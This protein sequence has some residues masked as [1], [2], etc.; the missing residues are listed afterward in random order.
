MF[1]T[2]EGPEGGGK[3]SAMSRLA[4]WLS[5]QTVSVVTTREP[6][7]TRLGEKIRSLLLDGDEP[8]PLASL[9]LFETARVQLVSTVIQPALQQGSMVLCDR[10]SDSTLAYQGYGDGLS[11]DDIRVLNRVATGGL[12][13][14]LTVL[15]DID[16]A[17]GLRRRD[18]AG[19]LN[20]MDRRDLDFHRRVREGFLALAAQEP[21]RWL[22]LDAAESPDV[23]H[24]RIV[25][26]ISSMIVLR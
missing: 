25:E 6:G 2:F 17:E 4:A 1:I 21:E 11:T 20:S 5:G 26:R 23:L 3:T 9:L 24:A 22:V 13:P 14:D 19:N 12:V 16:P 7:G 10:F 8:G 18:K 15:L